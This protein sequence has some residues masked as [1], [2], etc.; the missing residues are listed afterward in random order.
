MLQASNSTAGVVL[1]HSGTGREKDGCNQKGSQVELCPVNR[2]WTVQRGCVIFGDER[3][4]HRSPTAVTT[5]DIGV[6]FELSHCCWLSV[7][8]AGVFCYG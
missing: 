3:G 4:S 8:N 7:M 6:G 5:Q 2:T 1:L